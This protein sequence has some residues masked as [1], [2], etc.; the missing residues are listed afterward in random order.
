MRSAGICSCPSLWPPVSRRSPGVKIGTRGWLPEMTGSDIWSHQMIS[1]R[2]RSGDGETVEVE[3]C[4]FIFEDQRQPWVPG[5]RRDVD[6]IV[7]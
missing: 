4:F 7:S 6:N 1:L 3:T 5:V 2:K